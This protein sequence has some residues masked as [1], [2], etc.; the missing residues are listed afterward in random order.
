MN[1]NDLK[2]YIDI[3]IMYS[4]LYLMGIFGDKLSKVI[5]LLIV[6]IVSVQEKNYMTIRKQGIIKND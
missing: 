5:I 2:Y 1:K 3:V 4:N 6:S